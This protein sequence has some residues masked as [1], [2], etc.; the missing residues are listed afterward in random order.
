M[1]TKNIKIRLTKKK[2][3]VRLFSQKPGPDENNRY[4]NFVLPR[5]T[6]DI[7]FV[8]TVN[9]LSNIFSERSSLFH[10]PSEC[11]NILKG[12]GG[13]KVNRNCEMH[14]VLFKCLIF[15]RGLTSNGIKSSGLEY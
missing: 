8:E 10:T 4:R 2:K 3:E 9:I 5:E 14:A 6:G 1:Q 15:V 7:S 13:G 11:L 12:D